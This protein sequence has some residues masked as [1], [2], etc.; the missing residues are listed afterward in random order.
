MCSP[1]S[2]ASTGAAISASASS[3]T[4][5]RRLRQRSRHLHPRRGGRGRVRAQRH[6][7]LRLRAVPDRPR[8]GTLILDVLPSANLTFDLAPKLL[9]RL[10]AAETMARP[11]YS[12]LGGTVSLTD[13]NFTGSGGNPNLKPIKATVLDASI[14]YYYGP[15]SLVALSVFHDQ[16]QSYVTFGTS[17]GTYFTQ[18]DNKFPSIRDLVAGQH[19]RPAD[20]RRTA[21]A[22]ADRLR[23][24]LPGQRHLH[25]RPRKER[26]TVGRNVEV[27]LQSGRLL[28]KI[29]WS[30]PAWPTPIARII[31]S[32]SI[33]ARR[34][35]RPITAS[36]TGRSASM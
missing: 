31:S 36:S 26:R 20:G 35:T 8:S 22:A 34:R 9:L 1:I 5:G 15:A 27:H 4:R 19:Q 25:Q 3:D 30:A 13:T 17:T 23:L 24:R 11:D 14:E 21:G 33:A 12:A 18:L 10:A 6:H 29:A 16:L 28:S 2:A 7:D 32:A